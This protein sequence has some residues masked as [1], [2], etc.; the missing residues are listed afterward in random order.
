MPLLAVYWLKTILAG[1]GLQ[2]LHYEMF[3]LS[4]KHQ[5]MDWK[6]NWN[7]RKNG[8]GGR[9]CHFFSYFSEF[10]GYCIGDENFV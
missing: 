4:V 8:G 10:H 5:I 7:L 2:K 3:E 6:K 1:E 9:A